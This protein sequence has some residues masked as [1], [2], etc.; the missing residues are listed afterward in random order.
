V[1]EVAIPDGDTRR[2]PETFMPATAAVLL[3][4]TDAN[5]W[6]PHL[7][8]PIY[9][10]LVLGMISVLLVVPRLLAKYTTDSRKDIPYECGVDPIGTAQQRFSVHFYLVAVLFILFDI[11]AVFLFP[12]AV[13]LQDLGIAGFVEAIVFVA[14]LA[15]G[16][17]YAW[18]KGVLDWNR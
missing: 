16:L 6:A 9:V 7:A 1:A 8:F 3:A 14:I 11:E 2:R 5:A 12:W 17:G 15:L 13:A 4:D 10:L 18:R